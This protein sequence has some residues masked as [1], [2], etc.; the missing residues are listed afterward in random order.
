MSRIKELLLQNRVEDA[1]Q[2]CNVEGN[3]ALPKVVKSGL[4]R[5]GCDEFSLLFVKVWKVPTSKYLPK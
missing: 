4:E 1:I 5:I 2:Y 3:H